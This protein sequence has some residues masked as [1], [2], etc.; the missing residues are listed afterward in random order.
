MLK[1]HHVC[2]TV[3][4]DNVGFSIY[5][6]CVFSMLIVLVCILYDTNLLLIISYLLYFLNTFYK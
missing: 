3:F 2:L 6:E 4:Y 1:L 5:V